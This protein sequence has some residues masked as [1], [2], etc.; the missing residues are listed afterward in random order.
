MPV[1]SRDVDFIAYS[2]NGEPLLLVEVK[3]QRPTSESW[4]ARF[5]QNLMAQG[6]L[7]R[8]PFFLI[9][10][11]ERMYFWRQNDADGKEELP[12]FTIDAATELKPY[13]EKFKQT[14]EK[15]TGSALEMILFTWLVD[16]SQSGKARAREDSSIKWLSDS[17]LL[18]ALSR[19][20]I[21]ASTV[22]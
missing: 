4:A 12:Q 3:G 19:A 10:T 6:S 22:G 18:D 1:S 9:A 5:R 17:G 15:A 14:P 8:A 7:P 20:R 2:N 16:L 11:P 13:F 21:E